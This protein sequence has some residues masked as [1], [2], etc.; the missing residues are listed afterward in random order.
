MSVS[1]VLPSYNVEKYLD[2]SFES[3]IKQT[4]Q[5]HEIIYID[6]GSTDDTLMKIKEL[7][8]K[9]RTVKYISQENLGSGFARNTGMKIATGNYVYFMDPDDSIEND[10]IES[11]EKYIAK[12][13]NTDIF[14]FGYSIVDE[15]DKIITKNRPSCEA[16]IEGN[17][18]IFNNIDE[19]LE[20][21][22]Q[23]WNK[24]YSLNFL[25]RND[26][27]F[28]N[29]KAS[30]DG[31]FNVSVFANVES[32]TIIPEVYYRYLMNRPNSSRTKIRADR[33]LDDISYF[34]NLANL[35]K[36]KESISKTFSKIFI[37]HISAEF[38]TIKSKRK[39]LS[40]ALSSG[41]FIELINYIDGTTLKNPYDKLNYYLMRNK[42]IVG[43]QASLLFFSPL[44]YIYSF[45]KK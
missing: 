35:L 14:I 31:M 18:R 27:F 23:I 12:E 30:Q 8:K 17:Q 45:L 6:D 34:K 40:D 43:L 20:K 2:K 13:Q 5:P 29:M 39:I 16:H 9:N 21:G 42:S 10:L 19:Y 25:R 28:T 41:D 38:V 22:F 32:I 11:I 3:I 1:I 4:V 24:V 44:R 15:E 7:S 33:Y 37:R 26:I 36:Q